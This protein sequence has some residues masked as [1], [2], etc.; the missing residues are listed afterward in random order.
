MEAKCSAVICSLT[1]MLSLLCFLCCMVWNQTVLWMKLVRPSLFCSFSLPLRLSLYPLLFSSFTFH[2]RSSFWHLVDDSLVFESCPLCSMICSVV[3]PLLPGL[4]LMLLLVL[5]PG[6]QPTSTYVSAS[7]VLIHNRTILI[8]LCNVNVLTDSP[9]YPRWS[10]ERPILLLSPSHFMLLP[11]QDFL[12]Q[13]YC[14]L[15][16][17]VGSPASRLEKPL[18]WVISHFTVHC[19]LRKRHLRAG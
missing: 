16:E 3:S 19:G 18:G 15:G 7:D 5:H 8:T 4:S 14:T 9:C 13:V 6:S 17:I 10:P 11:R 1:V 12:G 2:F